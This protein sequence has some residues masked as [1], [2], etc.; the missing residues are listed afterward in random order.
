MKRQ[1]IL[2]K[3]GSFF[4]YLVRYWKKNLAIIIIFVVI[5]LAT[6]FPIRALISRSFDER[7]FSNM[8]E[9][10]N[11]KVALVLGAGLEDKDDASDIL[12][13]RVL[14]AVEMYKLGKVDKIIMSGDNRTIT[15]DEPS[16]MIAL[17]K[18][19][20]VP[21]EDLQPDYAGRRTYDSCFRARNIFTLSELVVITQEFHIDRAVYICSSL[22]ITTYGVVADRRD[23]EGEFYL[24][25]R[26]T[27]A[28]MLAIWDV[29]VRKP[30]VVLGD[31]I[32]I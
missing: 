5:L 12:E 25:I 6:P 3:I 21:E 27:Y 15:H 16:T 31:K 29:N 19:N 11:I 23:Y 28:F 17:A 10:P 9:V 20:G 24:K 30:E 18:E 2:R 4:S 22:G 1:R 13:D 26:D 7:V 8:G 32:E 14:T